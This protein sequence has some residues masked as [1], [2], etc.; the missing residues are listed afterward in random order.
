MI[1]FLLKQNKTHVVQFQ[2]AG[3]RFI[4]LVMS[5]QLVKYGSAP[6]PSVRVTGGFGFFGFGFLCT[7]TKHES[8]MTTL[9]LYNN[10]NDNSIDD[11]SS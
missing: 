6:P 1:L 7:N 9:I 11:K 5:G 8:M 3:F 10:N 2:L 4:T